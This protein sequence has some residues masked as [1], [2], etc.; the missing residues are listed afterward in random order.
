MAADNRRGEVGKSSR[1]TWDISRPEDKWREISTEI[2]AVGTAVKEVK[3]MEQ[4]LQRKYEERSRIFQNG[5]SC[6]SKRKEK[7]G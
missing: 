3:Y 5:R 7:E 1:D 6:G 2:D 4:E